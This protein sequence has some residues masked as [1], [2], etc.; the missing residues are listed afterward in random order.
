MS[1]CFFELSELSLANFKVTLKKLCFIIVN[2]KYH[3]PMIK[4]KINIWWHSKLL[5]FFF[6]NIFNLLC[7]FIGIYLLIFLVFILLL[8]FFFRDNWLIN[9]TF[10]MFY[11]LLAYFVL[12]ICSTQQQKLLTI[13]VLVFFLKDILYFLYACYFWLLSCLLI[14]SSTCSKLWQ[15]KIFQVLCFSIELASLILPF[16]YFLWVDYNSYLHLASIMCIDKTISFP[17][18]I[19]TTISRYKLNCLVKSAL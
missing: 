13:L 17:T 11:M 10:F 7:N 6:L 16:L 4:T 14:L 1:K 9:I 19:A 15:Y 8:V 3:E 5:L 12:S 18:Y 2:F